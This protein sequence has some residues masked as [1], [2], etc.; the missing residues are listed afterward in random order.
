MLSFR[1][2]NVA[3]DKFGYLPQFHWCLLANKQ[4][5]P[6]RSWWRNCCCTKS[7]LWLLLRSEIWTRFPSS[8]LLTLAFPLTMLG[9][10]LKRMVLL[11][12]CWSR[13]SWAISLLCWTIAVLC[14]AMACTAS[15]KWS[16][17]AS[18]LCCGMSC[19]L[20]CAVHPTDRY[21]QGTGSNLHIFWC[22]SI[23]TRWTVFLQIV[24]IVFMPGQL[25]KWSFPVTVWYSP[26]R[27]Q[28]GHVWDLFGHCLARWIS[29]DCLSILAPQFFVHSTVW[30]GHLSRW[31]LMYF[32]SPCHWQLFSL[33]LH[34][35]NRSLTS[36]SVR[37]SLTVFESRKAILQD[38]HSFRALPF[39][40]LS[41]QVLQV[42]LP[43]L[44]WYAWR[45]G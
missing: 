12:S 14:W 24:Q 4:C 37:T 38:G 29:R 26:I 8:E 31:L 42:I 32:S 19:R 1:H 41:K 35:T 3:G 5:T 16:L 33:L 2:A 6:L 36:L 18:K 44:C 34:F 23:K 7:F 17:M 13:F 21:W 43:Q 20:G 45:A 30:Y 10:P 39:L 9:F 28:C 11:T 25:C 27:L 15:C 22:I 40:Y